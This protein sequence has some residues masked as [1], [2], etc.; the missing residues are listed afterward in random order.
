MPE[1]VTQEHAGIAVDDTPSA[2]RVMIAPFRHLFQPRKAGAI[3]ANASR[4]YFCLAFG[5]NMLVLLLVFAAIVTWS[6]TL[7]KKNEGPGIHE[8]VERSPL[9]VWAGWFAGSGIDLIITM[10]LLVSGIIIAC[11]AALAWLQRPVMHS[12]A[13][14]WTTYKRAFRVVVSGS[15]I[16]ALVGGAVSLIYVAGDHNSTRNMVDPTRVPTNLYI[17]AVVLA[18]PAAISV[19]ILWVS[20]AIR[21]TNHPQEDEDITPLCEGCGYNLSVLPTG[22]RC[23]ECGL[24]IVKSLTHGEY[25]PG[26][27]WQIDKSARNWSKTA[28]R[29]LFS[30]KQFYSQ[31]QTK[32]AELRGQWFAYLHYASMAAFGAGWILATTMIISK[33]GFRAEELVFVV[34]VAA[35]MT[36]FAA[37]GVHRFVG[38]AVAMWWHKQDLQRNPAILPIVHTYETVYLWLFCAFNGLFITSQLAIPNWFPG[39]QFSL[40]LFG[41]P[42]ESVAIFGGNGILILLWIR[43]YHRALLAVR[44]ANF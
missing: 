13:P 2:M 4:R 7:T 34:Y 6:Q 5:F 44:W 41:L 30:P 19:L 11:A 22:G 9:D 14:L 36:T 39:L 10:A 38:A 27:A 16:L 42:P 29:C 1:A 35:S 28:L 23:T 8:L 43:R 20:K 21:G 32:S 31:T 33:S 18:I 25:R 12:N 3:L 37:W 40:S 17:Q 15:G 26:N 24:D